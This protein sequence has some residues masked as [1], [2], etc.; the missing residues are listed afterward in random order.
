MKSSIKALLSF[1][2]VT[3]Y[4][5]PPIL[6]L[7]YIRAYGV[8]VA[9]V[10]DFIFINGFTQLFTGSLSPDFFLELHNGHCLFFG[11]ILMLSLGL[12]THF[13]IIAEMYLSWLFLFLVLAVL[14]YL[15]IKTLGRK[16]SSLFMLAPISLL[17]FSL[18]PW[19]VFLNGSVFLNSMTIFFTLSSI[20]L[21]SHAKSDKISWHLI[22]AVLTAFVG[23]FSG[24]ASG[25]LIWPVGM[26]QLM[27]CSATNFDKLCNPEL[28]IEGISNCVKDSV[29]H[30]GTRVWLVSLLLCF[31]LYGALILSSSAATPHVAGTLPPQGFLHHLSLMPPYLLTLL[32]FPFC[33]NQQATQTCGVV[34]LLF[35][36]S[37]VVFYFIKK[38]LGQRIP[39]L[40]TAISIFLFGLCAIALI[41]YGRCERGYLEATATRYVQFSNIL[42]LGAYLCLCFSKFKKSLARTLL[43]AAFLGLVAT[44]AS[45]GYVAAPVAGVF[46]RNLQLKNAYLLRTY[47]IQTDSDLSA[48]QSNPIFVRYQAKALEKYHLNVFSRDHTDLDPVPEVPG[49]P[50]YC[51]NSVSKGV[52]DVAATGGKSITISGWAFDGSSK[53]P[54]KRVALLVDDTK[55]IP[56]CYGMA[57]PGVA[58]GFHEKALSD[59]GF[60]ASFSPSILTIGKHS[61]GLVVESTSGQKMAVSKPIMKIDVQ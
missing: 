34:V 11:K 56:A 41:T 24:S 8:N 36:L 21:L 52:I 38:P 18:R 51:L 5:L 2:A 6:A 50:T 15:V 48:L 7:L 31:G 43:F 30:V 27:P 16:L 26:L 55:V 19:D 46:W 57:Y 3:L 53:R 9:V 59:C 32:G 23:T 61:I 20:V 60:F 14:A 49:E 58:E 28:I 4:L 25:L 29:K 22:G 37:V 1:V 17:I 10:D 40:R 33:A 13:N 39:A 35:Y 42:L 54:A 44:T 45:V 47:K 12:A